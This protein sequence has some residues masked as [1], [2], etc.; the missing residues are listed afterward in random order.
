MP[1]AFAMPNATNSDQMQTM[2]EDE[3]PWADGTRPLTQTPED[4]EQSA[5][6]NR[7]IAALE[8]QVATLEKQ[9]GIDLE[10]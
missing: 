8:Y 9:S 10:E 6:L 7:R 1:K 2:G 5:Q 3:S 4:L